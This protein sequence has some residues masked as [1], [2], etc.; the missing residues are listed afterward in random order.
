MADE[1]QEFEYDVQL[2]RRPDD[3]LRALY[4]GMTVRSTEAQNA[5]RAA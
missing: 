5:L 4:P 3:A 1:E 2:T